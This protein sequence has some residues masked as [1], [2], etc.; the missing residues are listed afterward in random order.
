[1]VSE[2]SSTRLT[3][4]RL[5]TPRLSLRYLNGFDARHCLEARRD[6]PDVLWYNTHIPQGTECDF[7]PEEDIADPEEDDS[8]END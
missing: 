8:E 4:P 1:M 3:N 5:P 6:V 2:R 7:A